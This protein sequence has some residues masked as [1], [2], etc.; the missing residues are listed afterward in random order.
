MKCSICLEKINRKCILECGHIFHS[1]CIDHWGIKKNTC[2]LC[3]K[4]IKI[5]LSAAEIL[6]R[7]QIESDRKM[8]QEIYE[9]QRE[10]LYLKTREES[11]KKVVQ[12]LPPKEVIR[13]MCSRA[14]VQ[15]KS[16][17]TLFY[18]CMLCKKGCLSRIGL[19]SHLRSHQRRNEL[20]D[21]V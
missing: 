19:N 1:E 12:K 11:L 17:K 21:I 14:Y 20:I 13:I 10:K 9:R 8:A 5:K 6:I 2:P 7:D 4:T 15:V 16:K 18:N 3:R